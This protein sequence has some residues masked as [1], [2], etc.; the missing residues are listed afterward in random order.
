MLGLLLVAAL[1]TGFSIQK[2][3]TR[4]PEVTFKDFIAQFPQQRLPY[5]LD[6]VSLQNNLNFY[7]AKVNGKNTDSQL[8]RPFD[9]LDWAY[10]KFLPQLENEA[11]FSRLPLQVE[12]IALFVTNEYRAVMYSTSR[13]ARYGYGSYYITVFDR[14]EKYISTNLIGCTNPEDMMSADIT[15]DLQVVTHT[16]K[17]N[18]KNEYQLSGLHNNRVE[19]ISPTGSGQIDLT[20]PKPIE[21]RSLKNLLDPEPVT[22]PVEQPQS[23]RSK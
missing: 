20:F 18:W 1:L 16:W 13:G 12:P 21:Q 19:G 10:Y 22:L 17:V 8:G 7:V 6:A 2:A 11:M 14:E 9:K 4:D 23:V 3:L 5:A 15:P